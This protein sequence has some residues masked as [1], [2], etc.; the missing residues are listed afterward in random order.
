MQ[1]L[2]LL[3]AIPE[4][5]DIIDDETKELANSEDKALEQENDPVRITS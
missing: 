2:R 1:L 5:P 3:P 4:L